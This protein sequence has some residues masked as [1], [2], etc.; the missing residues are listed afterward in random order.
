MKVFSDIDLKDFKAWNGGK[1]AL[2]RILELGLEDEVQAYIE[3]IFPDGIEDTQLNDFLWFDAPDEFHLFD[4]NEVV[5][6]S[7]KAKSKDDLKEADDRWKFE[8]GEW[9]LDIDDEFWGWVET[10]GVEGTVIAGYEIE[11][12][13]TDDR[14]FSG[15]ESDED[16]IEDAKQWVE[17]KYR[18]FKK[19]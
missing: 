5:D 16:A 11:Y 4:N 13:P 19:K 2:D 17:E 14:R 12:S 15:Y 3:D 7:C 6:E 8:G 9:V 18:K 10:T 1:D